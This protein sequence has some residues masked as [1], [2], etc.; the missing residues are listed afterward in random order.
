MTTS[1]STGITSRGRLLPLAS[2]S[3]TI[4]ATLLNTPFHA[5]HIYIGLTFITAGIFFRSTH[6]P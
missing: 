6:R 5:G 2:T 3:Q 1:E 4:D